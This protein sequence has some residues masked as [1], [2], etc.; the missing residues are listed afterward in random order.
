MSLR[1]ELVRTVDDEAFFAVAGRALG[2]APA[3]RPPPLA[4]EQRLFGAR[5]NPV[6]ERG[7]VVRFLAWRGGDAAGRIVAWTDA[8]RPG[9]TYFGFFDILDVEAGVALVQ[10]ARDFGAEHCCGELRGPVD[11]W[12]ICSAGVPIAGLDLPN[13]F[14]LHHGTAHYADALER[15]GLQRAL[16]VYTWR[17]GRAPVPPPAIGIARAT[18]ANPAITIVD[19]DPDEADHWATAAELYERCYADEDWFLPLTPRELHLIADDYIEP[20]ASFLTFVRGTPAAISLGLRNVV[21]TS[22]RVGT[23]IPPEPIQRL[24]RTR[25]PQNY[26]LWMWGVAPAFRGRTL[27]HLSTALYVRL[28]ERVERAGFDHGEAAWTHDLETSLSAAFSML[29][30]QRDKTYRVFRDTI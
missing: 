28:R 10:A 24:A 11:F 23:V 25:R 4:W 29:G 3:W 13:T 9:V 16:D 21:E 26:R 12:S 20:A 30:A 18:L 14:G 6:Y 5:R 22:V 1:V 19:F 15:A 8:R 2:S 7:K 17:F 27:G